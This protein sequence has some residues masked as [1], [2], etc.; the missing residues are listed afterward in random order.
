M[1]MW[2]ALRSLLPARVVSPD[3]NL[4]WQ[5][6]EPWAENT[7]CFCAWFVVQWV[8]VQGRSICQGHKGWTACP[9]HSSVLTGYS[10]QGRWTWDHAYTPSSP[11]W[12]ESC[13]K[14]IC[15]SAL[16]YRNLMLLS[17]ATEGLQQCCITVQYLQLIFLRKWGLAIVQHVSL[18]VPF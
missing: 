9:R 18:L 13:L 11:L 2:T 6:R 1:C 5:E 8:T 7:L 10:W 3:S 17:G 16:Q 15:Q 14:F 4:N 12:K